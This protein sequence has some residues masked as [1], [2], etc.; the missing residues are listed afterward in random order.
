MIIEAF[1]RVLSPVSPTLSRQSRWLFAE[2]FKPDP[3]LL[4]V[5]CQTL[6]LGATKKR[7]KE[8]DGI[9]KSNGCSNNT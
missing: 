7:T 2:V 9:W 8:E 5:G 6:F 3:C 1:S 4:Y